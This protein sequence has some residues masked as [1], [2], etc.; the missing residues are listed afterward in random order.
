M[1]AASIAVT[2]PDVEQ[3]RGGRPPKAEPF[4]EFLTGL[5]VANPALTGADLL[6]RAKSEGYA[7]GKSALYD[8]AARIRVDRGLPS[9]REQ[10]AHERAER[11]TVLARPRA[12]RAAE[13]ERCAA[14]R[15][16][17]V[18]RRAD[19]RQ[20]RRAAREERREVRELEVF[21]PIAADEESTRLRVLGRKW[22]AERVAT[23][24][25]SVDDMS[26]WRAHVGPAFGDLE[27]D[28]VDT[29]K[30]RAFVEEKLAAGLVPK[31]VKNCMAMLSSLFSDLVDQGVVTRN[32]VRAIPK[33]VKRLY[34]RAHDPRTTP[35]IETMDGIR[36]LRRALPEPV[37]TMFSVAVL[38]GLRS[39]E[40]V[41][42]EWRDIS[43]DMRL[44]KV[45]RRLR[46]G[47]LDIPKSDKGRTVPI[48]GALRRILTQWKE[49]SG[50]TGLV[51][52]PSG[53]G[54]FVNMYCDAFR[55]VWYPALERTGLP[56]MR[57]YDATRH[58][59]ASQWVMAGH[60]IEKLSKILGHSSVM[61]TE[62]YAHLK[63]EA[64]TV[65]DVISF[66]D[67]DPEVR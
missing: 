47:K 45:Q 40:L 58:T 41:A 55:A 38:S 57:F 44:I 4:R 67:G 6:A 37:R 60:S 54:R 49:A 19:E 24:K 22:L 16:A 66:D 29:A 7:G 1:S 5:L 46:L 53:A 25:S 59:Y 65:P 17:R 13:R 10:H 64:L 28:E 62:I 15:C 27:P 12:E 33:A 3:P 32:P 48:S 39:G 63:P 14:E 26:R 11:E 42:L 8:L 20:R 18:Q 35:F 30:L 36:R 23:H 31:T 56:R 50:G 51:F 43:A 34:R 2:A 52:K 9:M 61:V 21:R